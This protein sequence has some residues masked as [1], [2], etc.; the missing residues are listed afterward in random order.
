MKLH[1]RVSLVYNVFFTCLL[2][3]IRAK[4]DRLQ[5]YYR[6]RLVHCH[7]NKVNALFS[8]RHG[9]IGPLISQGSR[10]M[11]G[12]RAILYSYCTRLAYLVHKVKSHI[13][14]VPPHLFSE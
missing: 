6:Y 10:G 5:C 1:E 2:L 3:C 8:R 14:T 7:V 9:P 11:F 13:L 12:V 4:Q